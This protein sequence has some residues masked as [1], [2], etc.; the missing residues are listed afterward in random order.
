MAARPSEACGRKRRTLETTKMTPL[1]AVV[2][3]LPRSRT[4]TTDE[5]TMLKIDRCASFAS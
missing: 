2:K 4:P 5:L 1:R 3:R